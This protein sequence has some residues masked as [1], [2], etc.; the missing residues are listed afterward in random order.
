MPKQAAQS[1]TL[2]RRF[3][4]A[5][6]FLVL[7]IGLGTT[8]C[9]PQ[10]DLTYLQVEEGQQADSLYSIQRQKYVIQENDIL[11]VTVRSFSEE[12]SVAF[13]NARTQNLQNV[14]D[15]YFYITGYSVDS[16]GRIELP[17]VGSV[18]VEGLTIEE[19]KVVI[20]EKLSLYFQ[21]DAIFTSVQLSGIRFSVIGEVNRPGKYTIYQNQANIFEALALAGDANIYGKRREVQIIRQYP[22]GV[23]VIDLDLTDVSVLTNPDFMVQP[24]DVINVKPMKQKS[25]GIGE[26]GFTSFVQTL[27]II[28]SVLL[29]AVSLRNLSN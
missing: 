9:I 6:L 28:S 26:K 20:N 18:L 13:N 12:A 11:N 4:L 17:V 15:G 8:S 21:E 24:N 3:S 27:S 2:F 16:E 19:A 29:I 7:V 23:R 14:G 1:R 25:W 22:E 10:K 5:S